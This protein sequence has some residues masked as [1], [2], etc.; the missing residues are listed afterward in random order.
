[1]R[2]FMIHSLSNFQICNKV[3]TIVT[4]W[5][6]YIFVT[7]LSIIENLGLVF[8]GPFVYILFMSAMCYRLS[9][10]TDRDF[11]KGFLTTWIIS[12]FSKINL[13]V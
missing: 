2:T 6:H 11:L 5:V 3:L 12:I 1:M 4:M 13:P 7:D 9:E 10:D 8:W